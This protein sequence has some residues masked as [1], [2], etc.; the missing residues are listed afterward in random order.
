MSENQNTPILAR[1]SPRIIRSVLPAVVPGP[2]AVV[3]IEIPI[4]VHHGARDLKTPSRA[5]ISKLSSGKTLRKY[6]NIPQ[7]E[8]L[9]TLKQRLVAVAARL[10]GYT[11]EAEE[12]YQPPLHQRCI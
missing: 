3:A 4:T 2:D 6:K 8:I 10:K 11:K 1:T 9:E 12:T 5:D 7:D